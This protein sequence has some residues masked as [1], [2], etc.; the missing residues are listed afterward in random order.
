MRKLKIRETDGWTK[1]SLANFNQLGKQQLSL[2]SLSIRVHNRE[3]VGMYAELL[4]KLKGSLKKLNIESYMEPLPGDMGLLEAISES[5]SLRTLIIENLQQ[6][7]IP[8][9]ELNYIVTVPNIQALV[10]KDRSSQE[11]QSFFNVEMHRSFVNLQVL[12]VGVNMQSP[13][14]AFSQYHPALISLTLAHP[15]QPSLSHLDAIKI[16]EKK[17]RGFK[18]SA[19]FQNQMEAQKKCPTAILMNEAFEV[20]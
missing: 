4:T 6:Q 15:E 7:V 10:I 20:K 13:V 11:L 16:T 12:Y 9:K 18:L 3:T 5:T 8:R 1:P 14:Q 19:K 2:E 17:T